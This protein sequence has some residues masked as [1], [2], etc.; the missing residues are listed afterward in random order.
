[1]LMFVGI[2]FMAVPTTILL[3]KHIN[4]KRDRIAAEGGV[5][6]TDKQLRELGDRAPDFRYML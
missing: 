3:Y 1:M 5:Q 4:R 6:Y 2:G